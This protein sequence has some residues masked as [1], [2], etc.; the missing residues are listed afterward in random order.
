VYLDNINI[1]SRTSDQH[2]EHL[3]AVLARIS[4]ANLLL[5]VSKCQL[6]REEVN[7]LGHIIY[8]NGIAADPS[9]IDT[10]RQWPSPKNVTE[11]RSFI[12]LCS[13]YRK[14]VAGFATL[15]KP[16]HA[17]TTKRQPFIW[18]EEQEE[19]FLTLKARLIEAPVLASPN[20]EGEYVLDTDARQYGLGAV[21][22]QKQG[23]DIYVIAYASRC[24]SRAERNYNTTRRE[25]LAVIFGLKQFRAFLLGRLFLLRVDHSALSFLKKTPEV[26]G[27]AARSLEFIEEY[28][29]TI[30]HRSGAS[31]GNCDVLSR[32]PCGV[33]KKK[34]LH[35]H[36][37]CR[38]TNQAEDRE[39]DRGAA[40][41]E[42][43]ESLNFT[44]ESIAKA[45]LDDVGLKPILEAVT[46]A[47]PRPARHD[48]QSSSEETRAF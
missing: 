37:C 15:A 36:P 6:F 12:G 17:M 31:H 48:V 7:F 39:A 19:L 18:G 11:L 47:A 9:K 2:L 41:R 46:S 14:F 25:L 10:V 1:F 32:R 21:L 42:A 24:L 5:K 16:L 45:Q 8:A 35:G 38:R 13:Y 4:A 28:I 44:P 22:Q 30:Q 33:P 27:Q 34:S 20:D 23:D 26:M 40:G 29:F 3:E 43:D